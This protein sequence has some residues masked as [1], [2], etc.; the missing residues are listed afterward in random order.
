[1]LWGGMMTGPWHD[2]H[3]APMMAAPP[4]HYARQGRHYYTRCLDLRS[5][6]IHHD[7]PCGHHGVYYRIYLYICTSY[8]C[9]CGLEPPRKL[10]N[11]Y[12]QSA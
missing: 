1:M 10:K 2:A 5:Y 8:N 11:D 3:P 9:P 7:A 6:S 4:P 12:F